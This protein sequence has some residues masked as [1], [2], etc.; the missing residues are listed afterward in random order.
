MMPR[1]GKALSMVALL[2]AVACTGAQ[3]PKGD[4]GEQGAQGPAGPT[5]ATGPAGTF[6]GAFTGTATFSGPTNLNGTTLF[7][8]QDLFSAAM[9]GTYP[10]VL[11]QILGNGHYMC[12][13]APTSFN[14][15]S[16]TAS[17]AAYGSVVYT[18][19]GVFAQTVTHITNA[20]TNMCYG[21][22][23]YF[24]RNPGAAK[25]ISINAYLDNGPSYAYVDGNTGPN[26][27]RSTALSGTQDAFVNIPTGPFSLS[28]IVCSTDGPSLFL[29]INENFI[30]NENLEVDFDRTFHRNG[31]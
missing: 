19:E 30:V 27:F 8:G 5:G 16:D 31:M 26:G 13:A 4:P 1:R 10:A 2:C 25:A 3:G 22:L 21:T 11:S 15:G 18:K 24:L 14:V 28:F 20:C 17:S 6:S 7:N 12:G 29:S 9:R 23:T